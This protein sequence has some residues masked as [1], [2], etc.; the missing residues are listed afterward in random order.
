[1]LPA[2]V[3]RNLRSFGGSIFISCANVARNGEP[4]PAEVGRLGMDMSMITTSN[5]FSVTLAKAGDIASHAITSVSSP[6][7]SFKRASTLKLGEVSDA[8][9][10]KAMDVVV[11]LHKS[12]V[13]YGGE[14]FRANLNTVRDHWKKYRKVVHLL[15]AYLILVTKAEQEAALQ[16][17]RR[18]WM[19]T[20]LP[21]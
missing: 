9:V 5:S 1:M 4:A 11:T 16:I 10:G 3:E 19:N 17:A 13:N 12:A 15:A 7:V 2:V 20:I 14:R 8:G 18:R 21:Q 6:N